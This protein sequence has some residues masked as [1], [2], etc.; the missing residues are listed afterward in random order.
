MKANGLM[1][2]DWVY[3]RNGRVLQ[4]RQ[5]TGFKIPNLIYLDFGYAPHTNLFDV[6][7][8]EPIPITTEILEKNGFD[9]SDPEV[10]QYHFED[11]TY[12]VD[13]KPQRLHFSIRQMYNKED[14]PQGY[15]FFAFNVLTIIDYVHQLQHAISLCGIEKEIIL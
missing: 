5:V 6:N 10:A 2:G 1:I 12:L 14:K 4:P 13:G 15:S 3:L 9:V 7:E 11:P 8:V